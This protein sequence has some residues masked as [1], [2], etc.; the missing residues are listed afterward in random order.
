[1]VEYPAKSG[2]PLRTKDKVVVQIHYNLADVHGIEDQ[3]RIALRTAKLSELDNLALF[4]LVDPFLDSIYDSTPEQL[5][6]GKPSV[7]YSWQRSVPQ[8][9]LGGVADITL[10][11]VMPHMHELGHKYRMN[12]VDGT[13]Q[14]CGVD[15]Q[16]WDFH[17]QR[18]Y[19]Y[20]EPIPLT[21]HDAIQVTCDF[22]TSSK[23]DPVLPGWGTQNEMC[24]ATLFVTV[25]I[26][27]PPSE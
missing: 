19:F 15:V 16:R 1:V 10:R 17:W 27:P 2:A 22:D 14:A 12:V 20:A 9:G 21:Q 24:L 26:A 4:P 13:Q 5:A 3:T 18:M 25:P 11:G 8:L 23:S 6:P 7:K